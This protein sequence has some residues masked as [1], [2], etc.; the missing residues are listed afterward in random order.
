MKKSGKKFTA[1]ILIG[2]LAASSPFSA[3]SGIIHVHA[4][5]KADNEPRTQAESKADNE[6]RTQAESK[7]DHEPQT[8]A[9]RKTNSEP[10]SPEIQESSDKAGIGEGHVGESLN[11]EN[12]EKAERENK[13]VI[14]L[15][16]LKLAVTETG[17]LEQQQ[18][19]YNC[20]TTESW[21]RVQ[22]ALDEARAVLEKQEL[23]Q[24]E[25]DDAFLNLITACDLLED[26]VQKTGLK[27]AIEGAKV[28]LAD[29]AQL[30]GYTRESI[31]AVRAALA[32][33]E[34]VFADITADTEKVN[35]TSR[36]LM[37]AVTNMK[38]TKKPSK[39]ELHAKIAEAKA[40]KKGN[41]TDASFHALTLAIAAAEKAAADPN[42]SQAVIDAQ[43]NALKNAISNLKV[44]VPQ[45]SKTAL[46]AKIAQAKAIKIGNYTN[47]SFQALTSAIAAAEKVAADPKA[48]QAAIDAQVNALTRAIQGLRIDPDKEAAVKVQGSTVAVK[49][50]NQASRYIKLS[51]KKV[52][53]ADGYVVM[54]KTSKGWKTVKTV[55]KDSSTSYV[56]KKADLGRRY[57]FAVK[58]YKKADGKTVYSKYKDV[59][60]KAVPQSPVIKAKVSKGRVTVSWKK[61]SNVV[62]GYRIYRKTGKTWSRIGI[63]DCSDTSFRDKKVKKGKTYTYKVRAYKKSGGK[64]IY[65]RYSNEIKVTVKK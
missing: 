63:T 42:A 22:K 28:I 34:I 54:N 53:G 10:L 62:T 16:S 58:A 23:T 38:E 35:Q 14:D 60:I 18:K 5:S 56:Y 6:P 45:P 9:E 55:K 4:E 21:D 50:A 40:I 52:S 51:W 8:Q 57:T 61:V 17:K 49:A 64:N 47:A 41:Y 31:D 48:T 15:D 32:E 1:G 36:K 13:S 43:V 33:A 65:S 11:V 2:V 26:S 27:A 37:D 29:E 25:I 20:F 7:T 3:L 24:Q 59:S 12:V 19:D 46:N 39:A 44:E 30:S